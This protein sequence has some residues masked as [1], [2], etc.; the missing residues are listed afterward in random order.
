MCCMFRYFFSFEEA[1][2]MIKYFQKYTLQKVIGNR[3]NKAQT[4]ANC[5][6]SVH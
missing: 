2:N 4:C 5:D 1:N 3:K 6:V